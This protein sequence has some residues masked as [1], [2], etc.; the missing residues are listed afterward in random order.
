MKR[1]QQ[2]QLAD[3]MS[4]TP[5]EFSLVGQKK[6]QQHQLKLKSKVLDLNLFERQTAILIIQ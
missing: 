5:K 6:V 4:Q 3:P 2:L 1:Q